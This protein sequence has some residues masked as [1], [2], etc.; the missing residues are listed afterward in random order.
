MAATTA[1][2][3]A[4]A[5]ALAITKAVEA[6]A[7]ADF[8]ALIY[9]AVG[10]TVGGAAH[11]DLK[12]VLE[13]TDLEAKLRA[14]DALLNQIATPAPDSKTVY[15]V[16]TNNVQEVV[17]KIHSELKAIHQE[18]EMHDQRWFSYY[19]YP[20]YYPNLENLKKYR[21]LLDSRTDML[22]KVLAIPTGST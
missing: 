4:T 20:A 17:D 2:A 3:A 10:W 5:G 11:P 12:Q 6:H 14:V 8:V 19:R 21:E 13:Q 9:K 16:C 7:V 22:I 1:T 18:C 15:A